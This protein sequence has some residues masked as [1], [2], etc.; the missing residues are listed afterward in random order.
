LT[1]DFSLL[2]RVLYKSTMALLFLIISFLLIPDSAF[3]WGPLTHIYLGNEAF[4]L[5]TIL[6]AHLF[7]L[8]IRHREDFLY[9]NIVAD[10]IFAK[11]LLPPEKN[12]H[13][14][15]VGFE[16]LERAERDSEKAF[17]YGYLCHLASDT[18]AH[19]DLA[20]K[21]GLSHTVLELKADRLISSSYWIEAITINRA[22]QK[23]NDRFLKECLESALFSFKT[24]K[25]LFK[26]LMYL[27]IFN[28]NISQTN[29]P[30]W[31][32]EIKRLHEE[33]LDRMI[34]VLLKGENSKVTKKKA[35]IEL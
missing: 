17:V 19:E 9:G 2:F 6:P 8:L 12:P 31:T 23:R 10:I 21:I 32:K 25:R 30:V 7:H 3:A 13:N 11:R 34:D 20:S 29:S 22:I 35:F 18:V 15:S 24:N 4:Y 33:S 1:D 26:G 27:S 14:W 28:R 16:M 5:S